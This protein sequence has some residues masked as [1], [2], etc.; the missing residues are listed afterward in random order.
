MGLFNKIK[1]MFSGTE[2]DEKKVL[3]EQVVEKDNNK[4]L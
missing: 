4:G 2:K 1:D 3:N